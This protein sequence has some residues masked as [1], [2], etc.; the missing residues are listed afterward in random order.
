MATNY[1]STHGMIWGEISDAG[2]T[3]SYGHDAL[4]SVIETFSSGTLLNTY[5][6]KPYGATLATTGSS[7]NPKYL[8]N[9]GSGYRAT[10]ITDSDFYVRDR[11]YV[12]SA[13]AWTSSDPIW[14]EEAPYAYA[15]GNVTTLGDP[16]GNYP[17]R[18]PISSMTCK[19]ATSSQ[20]YG[21]YDTTGSGYIVQ[22]VTIGIGVTN[23]KGSAVPASAPCM[24]GT[25][26]YEVFQT[27]WSGKNITPGQDTWAFNPTGALGRCLS[28]SVSWT[29]SLWFAG[30][31]M[32]KELKGKKEA[33]ACAGSIINSTYQKPEGFYAQ[34]T[35]IM[36]VTFGCCTNKLIL[37]AIPPFSV[38]LA[39]KWCCYDP[40]FVANC[41]TPGANGK[42]TSNGS[43][44]G[45]C[46]G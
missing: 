17:I 45:S 23:C 44:F 14:P 25:T 24:Q 39:P 10:A 37:A 27:S 8:W 22:E 43:G 46:S 42:M 2:V 26:Y 13:G 33:Q 36:Q 9:G 15:G 4:G 32:P 6:Y 19:C 34:E 18:T 5:R 41:T 16:S 12:S 11:H 31:T 40:N 35:A 1:I 21:V 28:G 30:P 3:T 7:P 20:S 38:Q 29:G